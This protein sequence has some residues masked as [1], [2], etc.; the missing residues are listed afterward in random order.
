MDDQPTA[1]AITGRQLLIEK[2]LL[3]ISLA[4]GEDAL[5]TS[6]EEIGTFHKDDLVWTRGTTDLQPGDRV[7]H[8]GRL[9]FVG[10]TNDEGARMRLA[11]ARRQPYFVCGR[12]DRNDRVCGGDDGMKPAC[13]RCQSFKLE[14]RRALLE[15]ARTPFCVHVEFD[16]ADDGAH[17]AGGSGAKRKLLLAHELE[18]ASPICGTHVEA[19]H[20]STFRNG[21]AVSVDGDGYVVSK[22][23]A[24]RVGVDFAY[25]PLALATQPNARTASTTRLV[26]GSSS[27]ARRESGSGGCVMSAEPL[28]LVDG[29]V[30][31]EVVIKK[32][33][34]HGNEGLEM[35]LTTI[36]PDRI[37][38]AYDYAAAVR[39]SWFSSDSGSLWK[40]GRAY[41]DEGQW[42]TTRPINLKAGDVVTLSVTPSGAM[43]I[44]CNGAWQVTWNAARVD[45]SRPLYAL[46]GMR[47]PL[48]GVALRTRVVD[49]AGATLTP[50]RSVVLRGIEG[51]TGE[52]IDL[53]KHGRPKYPAAF[54]NERAISDVRSLHPL[55]MQPWEGRWHG[56]KGAQP[57]LIRAGP[58][59]GKTWCV[60]Q[61]LFLLANGSHA[62][63]L[64]EKRAHV[65]QGA[66]TRLRYLRRG[67]AQH[68]ARLELTPFVCRQK[69][70]RLMRQAQAQADAAGRRARRAWQARRRHR[71]HRRHRRIADGRFDPLLRT[72]RVPRGRVRRGDP[73]DARAAL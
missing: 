67:C 2:Q 20:G 47:A 10:F 51:R 72:E 61:L 70:A 54:T 15:G 57:I 19:W 65:M 68:A 27:Q 39:P 56:R 44:H 45:L 69:L 66:A 3:N 50:A 5:R 63:P 1:R 26:Q 8:E 33:H 21:D 31:Y 22:R 62:L 46:V 37:A 13:A 4:T 59:T 18:K 30:S 23:S 64:D 25:V 52:T 43:V 49:V 17:H 42:A 9:G 48:C 16:G 32:Q 41:Y 60:M 36:P 11:K 71:R 53:S 29:G 38:L 28:K 55:L 12:V 40:D 73:C 35:G 6:G 34:G 14:H 58:G 7:R 24:K